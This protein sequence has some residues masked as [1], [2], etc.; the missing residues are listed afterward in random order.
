MPTPLPIAPAGPRTE[1]HALTGLRFFAAFHVVLFHTHALIGATQPTWL[2]TLASGGHHA[3]ALFFVLSGFILHHT[4]HPTDW[5]LP[6]E[7]RQY[8]VH[9]VARIYPVYLLSFLID[10]P[11]AV[12]YFLATYDVATGLLKAGITGAAYLTLTQT[13]A[14]RLASA[15]NPPGWSLSNEAFFYLLLPWLLPLVAR[16]TPTRALLGL[17]LATAAASLGQALPRLAIDTLGLSREIWGSYVAFF[18]PLRAFE[19]VFGVLL[20]R[21][22]VGA[23]QARHATT[24]A[25]SPALGAAA[26]LVAIAAILLLSNGFTLPNLGRHHG[27]LLPFYGLLIVSLT[28]PTNP[29]THLLSLPPLRFLGGA[30]YA[31]YLL[32][33]PLFTYFQQFTAHAQWLPSPATFLAYAGFV[34]LLASLVFRFY[35]EPL[36]RLIRRR[37]AHRSAGDGPPRVRPIPPPDRSRFPPA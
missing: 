31:I 36:R 26:S 3:V 7:R 5:A 21:L 11:R 2:V 18:P 12:G 15:W 35:E 23:S 17:A 29:V 8:L 32:H 6:G 4:Y 22:F 14:P 28:L 37:F 33:L 13:W 19:F 30:S 9:R 10:A 16:L 27:L 34:T 25:P 24:L 1:L 20:G